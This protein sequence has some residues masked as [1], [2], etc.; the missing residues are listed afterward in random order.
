MLIQLNDSE[1]LLRPSLSLLSCQL[2]TL[3]LPPVPEPSTSHSQVPTALPMEP[4]TALEGKV[5]AGR[6]HTELLGWNKGR[7]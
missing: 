5:S 4:G 1:G 3:A 2:L 6:Q 7:V